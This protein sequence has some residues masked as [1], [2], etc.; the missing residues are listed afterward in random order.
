MKVTYNWLKK[1]VDITAPVEEVAQRLTAVGLEVASL[2]P[3]SIPDG[4]IVADILEAEKLPDTDHLFICKV[5]TGKGNPMTIVCGAPNT[6]AGMKSALAM[7]GTVLNN[8]FTI[9]KAKIRGVESSGMLCSERELG[10]SENHEGILSLPRE[11]KTGDPLN[12]YI[13]ND[14]VIDID[15]TPNRG[16]CLSVLGVA[17]EVSAIYDT[18]LNNIARRPKESDEPIDKHIKVTI[19]DAEGCPRYMGRM[20]QGVTIKDSPLWLKNRLTALGIRPIS[21]VV[22]VTNY[23]LLLF[24]QPMHSFDYKEIAGKEIIVKRAKEGQKFTTLDE[25]ERTLTAEDLLICDAKE[26]TALAGVMGGLASGITDDTKDVFLECA[27]FNPVGIRKTSKRLDLSSDSSYRFERG[28]DPVTGCEDAVDTAAEMI[29]E[30]ADGSVAKGTIDEYPKPIPK[31]QIILR[32]PQVARLLGVTVEKDTIIKLLTSLQIEYISEKE[33]KLLFEVPQYRHDISLEID[34]IEEI[35]RLYGYDTIPTEINA[36]VIMDHKLDPAEKTVSSIRKSLASAGLHEAVTGTMTSEKKCTL[37]T[38]GT[39]PV[40]LLNPLNPEMSRMR[41][42]L[43]DSL[44]DITSYN[45]NRKNSNNRFFEIG[46]TFIKQDN[47]TLPHEPDIVAILLEGDYMPASW[48]SSKQKM[49]F[50]ILK[51]FV[52]SLRTGLSLPPFTYSPL[53]D[54][55]TY[56]SEESAQVTGN[57]ITGLMGRIKNNIL[58]NFSIKTPV[59][60]AELDITELLNTD[61]QRPLYSQLPRFPAINRDFCFVMEETLPSTAI[62]DQIYAISELVESVHPFDVYRG[63]K[64][65]EGMKSIAYSIQLRAEDRTLTDEEAEEISSNIIKTMKSKFSAVL[66]E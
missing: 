19:E 17:R 37:L 66:R 18:P 60:Y 62:A 42:T 56:F 39:K 27:Y 36:T 61:P 14:T 45:I 35:G 50:S 34:L 46:K 64:L 31:K 24:G 63:E 5:D 20:V 54:T 7:V 3:C 2:E 1:L 23:I 41:T 40:E 29:R 47:A 53:K 43:L 44:L 26:P 32:P 25:V 51:S 33:G 21:N 57:G 13:E 38:P 15:L 49:D 65:K 8:D 58:S 52:E 28:V 55:H 22:D 9:K 6:Q 59:Y 16:D 48:N 10:I 11:C 4:V 12:K 30:L